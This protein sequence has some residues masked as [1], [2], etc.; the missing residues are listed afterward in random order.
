MSNQRH[1]A[2]EILRLRLSQMLINDMYKAKAFRVP[3]HLA[4]GHE[5]VA[6]AVV[7]AMEEGDNLVLPHRNLHYNLAACRSLRAVVDEFLLCGSGLARGKYGSMNLINPEAGLI[8][9]SSILGNNMSVATGVALGGKVAGADAI[10][11]VVTGDGAM[12]EGAFY[13]SIVLMRAQSLPV[14]IVVENNEWSLASRIEERRGPIDL[15]GLA[16]SCEASYRRLSGNDVAAY[17][18]MFGELRRTAKSEQRPIVVEVDLKT[19]GDWR[20]PTPEFPEGKYINYH[21]GPAPTVSAQA[22][23]VLASGSEDPIHVLL[24]T[25]PESELRREA[26]AMLAELQ[27]DIA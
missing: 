26:S 20:Q 3:V 2:R 17:A 10:T 13:E 1:L 27:R 25:V 4:L 24:S 19:L 16:A 18:D 12:E 9:A 5:A 22:W 11:F 6:I 21:A 15:A 23:P 7:N 14:V 8:Y